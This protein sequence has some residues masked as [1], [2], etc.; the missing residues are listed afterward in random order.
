MR[1]SPRYALLALLIFA[2][3]V[4]IALKV[5]DQLVRPYL[6]D[7]LVV[8]LLH[9]CVLAVYRGNTLWVLTGVFAF[10]CAIEVGQYLQLVRLLG[11]EHS[12]F[13]RVVIGTTFHPL[14]FAAYALGVLLT[15]G[16][17]W[18]LRRLTTHNLSGT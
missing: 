4:L 3:E 18:A 7:A 2:T 9:C 16:L 12:H 17:E 10:A 15:L 1:F 6:G 5:H 14:D 11:L 13:W 8:V